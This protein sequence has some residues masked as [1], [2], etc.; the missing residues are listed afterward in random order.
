MGNPKSCGMGIIMN[1]RRAAAVIVLSIVFV[2]F[3]TGF[4]AGRLTAGDTYTIST[5]IALRDSEGDAEAPASDR[6][7]EDQSRENSEETSAKNEVPVGV[8]TAASSTEPEDKEPL[9]PIDINTS[10]KDELMLL[11][12]IGETRARNIIDYREKNGPFRSIADI[13][14]VSG[15]GEAIYDDIK[16]YITCDASQ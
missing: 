8:K 16:E 11:P 10:S 9:F 13:M 15:I 5:G 1:N 6:A 12:S 3:A 7:Q 2:S 14:Q 4:F